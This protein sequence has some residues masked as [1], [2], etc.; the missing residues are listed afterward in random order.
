MINDVEADAYV[1]LSMKRSDRI[2][3]VS[4]IG[5]AFLIYDVGIEQSHVEISFVVLRCAQHVHKN[6]YPLVYVY[7]SSWV[8]ALKRAINFSYVYNLGCMTQTPVSCIYTL[9]IP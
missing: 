5:W 3:I 2:R 1:K 4:Y 6:P 8:V 9:S 7:V